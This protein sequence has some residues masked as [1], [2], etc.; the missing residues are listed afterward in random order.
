MICL[1]T[2]NSPAPRDCD[3]TQARATNLQLLLDAALNWPDRDAVD[4]QD[5][6]RTHR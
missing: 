5:F 1:W 6:R 3:L 4:H 2:T